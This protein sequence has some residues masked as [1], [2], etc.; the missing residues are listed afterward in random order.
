MLGVSGYIVFLVPL[1]PLLTN[2]PL[3][4]ESFPNSKIRLSIESLLYYLNS[5]KKLSFFNVS[6]SFGSLIV[7]F[8]HLGLCILVGVTNYYSDLEENSDDKLGSLVKG[9]GNIAAMNFWISLLP[10]AKTSVWTSLT[11]VPFERSIRYH[12][13]AVILAIIATLI[14]LLVSG[15]ASSLANL[16]PGKGFIKFGFTAFIIACA[17]ALTGLDVFR[18]RFYETFKNFHNI[19]IIAIIMMILHDTGVI[20]GFMP[21]FFLQCIDTYRRIYHYNHPEIVIHAACYEKCEIVSLQIHHVT[22]D[23]NSPKSFPFGGYFL[24]N[25][26]AISTLEWHP[27]SA[28][29]VNSLDSTVTLHI[30]AQGQ[31]SFTRKVY[32]H[33]QKGVSVPLTV[34]M[35]GPFGCFS[36]DLS[37]YTRVCLIAGG[38]GITPLLPVL[39]AVCN[40]TNNTGS[41][42]RLQHVEKVKMVWA[43]RGRELRDVFEKQY[44]NLI[45]MDELTAQGRVT[46]K[47]KRLV[48][49]DIYDTLLKSGASGQY[50]SE[51]KHQQGNTDL[52][53]GLGL[54]LCIKSYGGR[55]ALEAIVKEL[56]VPVQGQEGEVCLIICGP[57]SLA[58]EAGRVANMLQI[59]YHVEIFGY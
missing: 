5:K 31:N 13:L 15:Y 14:H 38:I 45:E 24:V 54:D 20:F 46:G 35:Y 44:M 21:G 43:I 50:G 47:N 42:S 39:N 11:G 16:P 9:T 26:P 23:K 37:R 18:T 1:F 25:I 33:V 41:S 7:C 12:K 36:I 57:S 52:D 34:A 59:D 51:D 49:V 4:K 29:S 58:A 53:S 10:V 48:E 6:I 17:M 22:V 8:F 3:K 55:P 56:L 32:E 27:F 28:S 19:Y 40:R 30:K 2:I